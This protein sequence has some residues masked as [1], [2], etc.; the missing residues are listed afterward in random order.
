MNLKQKIIKINRKLR[1][2]LK[3]IKIV[4]KKIKYNFDTIK[5]KFENFIEKNLFKLILSKGY[6]IEFPFA[7]IINYCLLKD[8]S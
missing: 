7:S 6:F 2:N 5:Y 1:L 3:K 8:S 4:L